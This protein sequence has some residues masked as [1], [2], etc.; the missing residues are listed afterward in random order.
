MVHHETPGEEKADVLHEGWRKEK[1]EV[2]ERREGTSWPPEGKKRCSI[3]GRTQQSEALEP[4]WGQSSGFRQSKE[5]PNG[6]RR[7]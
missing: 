6:S 3:F 7:A 1:G 2:Q 4:S 5:L